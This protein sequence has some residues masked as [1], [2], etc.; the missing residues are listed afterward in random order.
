LVNGG[1]PQCMLGVPFAN[2]TDKGKLLNY[3]IQANVSF[4]S[5]SDI[6]HPYLQKRQAYCFVKAERIGQG[7][8]Y[9]RSWVI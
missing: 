1:P 3:L 2:F 9:A 4:Q 6:S 5:K 8:P 7:C